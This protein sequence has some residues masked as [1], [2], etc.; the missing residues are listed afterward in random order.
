[1]YVY[2]STIECYRSLIFV[3]YLNAIWNVINFKEAEQRLA[4]ATK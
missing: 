4:E 2:I 1:M 3:Q